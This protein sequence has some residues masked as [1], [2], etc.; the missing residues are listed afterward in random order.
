MWDLK[1]QHTSEYGKEEADSQ[2][3]NKPAVTS[4]ERQR[5][6]RLRG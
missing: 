4:G 3:W 5:K 2:T 1:T 6:R